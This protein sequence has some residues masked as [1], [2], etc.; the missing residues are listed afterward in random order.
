[1]AGDW[2]LATADA[3]FAR[4][5]RDAGH[6]LWVLP[7]FPCVSECGFLGLSWEQKFRLPANGPWLEFFQRTCSEYGV[8]RVESWVASSSF[9]V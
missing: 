1:M 3:L 4:N 9:G 8:L 2:M 5:L 6:L 7:S